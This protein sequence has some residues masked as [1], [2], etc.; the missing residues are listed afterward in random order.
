MNIVL[1]EPGETSLPLPRD[2]RRAHHILDILRCEVGDTFDAGLING[3]R[4]KATI[5]SIEAG[6]IQLSFTWG[7]EPATLDP[8][9]LIVGLPRPQTARKILE[10]ATALGVAAIHFV[11]SNRGE[12]SYGRSKL[13][14]TDEWRRHLVDG[15]AQAF[16]TRLPDITAWRPLR[17]AVD[18]LPAAACRLALDNYE[19]AAP[20][21][22]VA[23]SAPVALALGPE[24]GWSAA[25]RDQLRAAGFSIVHLGE[26]VLRL[27]TACVAAI[28]LVKARLGLY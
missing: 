12:A 16:T 20:L 28:A 13:W 18:D 9:V 17:E 5:R 14:V 1:F 15:A 7:D 21:A 10:E 24:P 27:E 26:R 3:P 6:S 23:V 11:A 4:G 25:E 8:I 2:D 22:G 19:A